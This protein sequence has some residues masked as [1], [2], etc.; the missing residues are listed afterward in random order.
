MR[1]WAVDRD[2]WLARCRQ[3]SWL[4]FAGDKRNGYDVA[5]LRANH[6]VRFAQR[7]LDP[8][9]GYAAPIPPTRITLSVLRTLVYSGSDP[10]AGSE[11][12]QG[13]RLVEVEDLDREFVF[14]ADL[15]RDLI[16][17]AVSA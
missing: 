11:R 10:R 1:V 5:I 14:A 7:V 6:L 13:V 8:R 17:D 16:H 3:E 4:L 15:D 12:G 2:A 9:N